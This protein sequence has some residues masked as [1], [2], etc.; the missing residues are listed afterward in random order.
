MKTKKQKALLILALFLGLVIQPACEPE[1]HPSGGN[2]EETPVLKLGTFDKVPVGGGTVEVSVQYNVDYTVEV[3]SAAQS[4][5]KLVQTKAVSNGKLVLAVSANTGAERSGKVTLTDKGGKAS[6]ATITITQ[7]AWVAVTAI[8]LDKTAIELETGKTVTLKA[9]LKPENASDKSIVWK[10]DNAGIAEVDNSGLVRGIAE[11]TA[12]VTAT[13]GEMSAS[14]RVTVVRSA[15]DQER[16]ALEAF[17]DATGGPQ[18]KNKSNW[19]SDRPLGEWYGLMVDD[20]G[21]VISITMADNNLKGKLPPEIGDFTRLETLY[22]GNYDNRTALVGA[23][24]QEIGRLSKLKTL[25]FVYCDFTGTLPDLGGLTELETIFLHSCRELATQALP[26]SLGKATR[27][28]KITLFRSNFAGPIPDAWKDLTE[29]EY[30]MISEVPVNT[31]F[32]AFFKKMTKLEYLSVGGCG[33]HGVLPAELKENPRWWRLWPQILFTNDFTMQDVLASHLPGPRG[34][35]IQAHSGENLRFEDLYKKNKYTVLFNWAIYF[36]DSI[37]YM[38]KLRRY[39]TKLPSGSVGVVGCFQVAKNDEIARAEELVE[40]YGVTW[41]QVYDEMNS[42]NRPFGDRSGYAGYPYGAQ[43]EV[44]VFDSNGELVYTSLMDHNPKTWLSDLAKEF[45]VSID[46]YQSTDFSADGKVEVLQKA[47]KGNGIDMVLM[48]DG[49]SDRL[50]ADGT[51]RKTLVRMMEGF[52]SEEPMKSF[53]HLFNVYGV[54]V[55]SKNEEFDEGITQTTLE[56]SF[57]AGSYCDGNDDKVLAYARKAGLSDDRMKEVLCVVALNKEVNSGTCFMKRPQQAGDYGMGAAV[58]YFGL[59]SSEFIGYGDFTLEELIL[60]E[61]AGHGLA[62]LGDEYVMEYASIPDPVK[63]IIREREKYG[64]NKNVSIT[65]DPAKVKWAH[66]LKDKRYDVEK[67]GVYEGA[68]TFERGA[69][70]PS[71]DSMM[72]GSKS[73]FNAPSREAIYIRMHKL[74]F[75]A[76]WKYDYEEFVKY[77]AINRAR[78]K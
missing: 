36:D 63:D 47:S 43:L 28:K 51:Y 53:R 41:P 23:I 45:N 1:V 13:A 52:F 32:P 70:R 4:W 5:I 42:Q 31:T 26:A 66:F 49:F 35:T 16:A 8:E 59:G 48:G 17:F 7:E 11:G 20:E 67:L 71:K 76:S 25:A 12:I 56:A 50:V 19:L 6:P 2:Q 3:E 62:K 38:Q 60:H 39:L 21:Y 72:N 27:L 73:M 69:W 78:Y 44:L 68:Y 22:L 75:G 58:A 37:E 33:L 24:P 14:C 40:R 46:Y 34:L 57:G 55:V 65:G 77:D 10:S 54:T 15:L 61:A 29:M 74:A 64:W 18:W 9:G 30:L